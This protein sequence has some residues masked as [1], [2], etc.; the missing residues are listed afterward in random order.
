MVERKFVIDALCD[1]QAGQ[2][3]SEEVLRVLHRLGLKTFS[4]ARRIISTE[5]P[6][7][8]TADF[9]RTNMAKMTLCFAE[10]D[11]M[12]H[13]SHNVTPISTPPQT[14]R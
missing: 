1:L 11:E 5:N 7:P 9:I 14:Q 12:N 2:K 4:D 6:R 3:S 10:I 13:A 8:Q